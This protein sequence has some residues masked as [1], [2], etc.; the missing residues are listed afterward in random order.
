MPENARKLVVQLDERLSAVGLGAFWEIG[1]P[2]Q[3]ILG[4]PVTPGCIG[5]VVIGGLNPIAILEEL[6]Y[7]VDSRALAGLL[8]YNRLYSFEELPQDLQRYL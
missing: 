1:L 5:S 6:G 8:D 2:G 7:R 3:S 4:L